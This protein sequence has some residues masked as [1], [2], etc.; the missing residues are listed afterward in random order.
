MSA[1]R[2]SIFGPEFGVRLESR[3][4]GQPKVIA[5]YGAVFYNAADPGGTEYEIGKYYRERIMPGAFDRAIREDDVRSLF[6]HD[7][8]F[9]LGRKSAGT[10]RLSVDAKGLR[11]EVDPPDTQAGRDVA[12]V[13]ERGDVSGSSFMFVPRVVR[14][15]QA[16][17]ID[18]REIVEVELWE[19]GPVVFPAY[20]GA[21]SGLRA[22]DFEEN[23]A[24]WKEW[25]ES[26]ESAKRQRFAREARARKVE[27]ESRP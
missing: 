19:V 17:E 2:R 25:R 9:V 18:I 6:N 22:H 15:V 14:W 12:T 3:A 4:E 23:L 5:G 13:I 1:E 7:T 27:I 21:T 26:L 24:A 11:Y 20:A 10:L 16:E 8:N